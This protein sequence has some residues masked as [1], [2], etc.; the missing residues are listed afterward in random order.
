MAHK[1]RKL[2]LAVTIL[3]AAV[4]AVFA[5]A[6]IG[7]GYIAAC[8][9]L[10]AALLNLFYYGRKGLRLAL[11]LLLAAGL[12]AFAL[13]EVPIVRAAKTDAP[14]GCAYIVVL[15]AGVNG[16][17]PS[18]SLVNRL[19]AAYDY[20]EDNPDTVAVVTGGQGPGEN[21]TEAEAMRIWLEARGIASDRIVEE[22]RAVSTQENLAFS[23]DLIRAR[24]GDAQSVAVVSSEYHLWRAKLLAA[25][26]G[27]SVAGIA[28]ETT[29]PVLRL[30]Y[31]IREGAVRAYY[32]I[33][34]V[35]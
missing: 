23:F 28:G 16:D 7:Y 24:G 4:S 29:L 12:L 20:L 8:L 35:A 30:N 33:F 15:G 5:F 14:S 22:D 10:A 2:V 9:L 26:Q 1:H 11:G 32:L 19:S 17:T 18:L 13:L 34:G 27:V 25:Q 21:L 3:L 6:L 31:F